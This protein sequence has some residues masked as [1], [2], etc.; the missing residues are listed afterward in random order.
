MCPQTSLNTQVID[1]AIRGDKLALGV[2]YEH[3]ADAV[4][5]FMF[6]RT[7]NSTIA[8]DLTAEVFASVITSISR[9]ENREDQGVPFEAWLFRI[10]RARLVD[11]WRKAERDQKHQVKISPEME[12]TYWGELSQDP[13]RYETLINALQY[14]TPAEYEVVALRFASGFDNQ[15]ISV[16]VERTSDAVKSMLH[17]A[18]KKLR[19]ILKRQ[20]EFYGQSER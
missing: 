6:Y 13:F 8:E 14:L 12:E 17:R 11:Y 19:Q 9:Y 7:K 4:Y 10:A 2:L 1:R 5:R 18:L 3:Y 15:E 20:D 16:V